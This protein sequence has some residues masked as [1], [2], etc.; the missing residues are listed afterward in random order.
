MRKPSKEKGGKIG[1]NTTDTDYLPNVMSTMHP[2]E[3]KVGIG[4][5]VVG[6][7]FQLT[8]LFFVWDS[9]TFLL[10]FIHCEKL[11]YCLRK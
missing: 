3:N 6:L 10:F 4:L 7:V 8:T 1:S 11:F 2:T 9:I 5:A